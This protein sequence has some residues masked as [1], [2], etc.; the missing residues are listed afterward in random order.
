VAGV[1]GDVVA[2]DNRYVLGITK[3]MGTPY[4]YN[5]LFRPGPDIYMNACVGDNGGPY[6]FGAYAEGFFQ[7]GHRIFTSAQAEGISP[8]LLVYPIAFSYRH[9]IELYL[10]HLI[11]I[12][13][14]RLRLPIR[15]NKNHSLQENMTLVTSIPQSAPEWVFDPNIEISIAQDIIEDFC[16][17]D[18]TGQ[19]FRYPEDIR[20]NKH[21]TEL[22]VINLEVLRD[23]MKLLHEMLAK[24]STNL[25]AL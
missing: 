18:P 19:V 20:G 24:W 16:Q 6:S 13:S 25:E 12:A 3:H 15:Y 1:F 21:L 2:P 4:T 10:K 5:S 22:A 17:I 23:G 11:S 9:G 14:E 7:G 8:D